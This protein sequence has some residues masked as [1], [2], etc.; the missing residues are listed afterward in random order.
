MQRRTFLQGSIA[1]AVAAAT[2]PQALAQ[3]AAA[4][5]ANAPPAFPPVDDRSVWLVGDWG[6]PP[7]AVV[8]STRLATLV[9][10]RDDVK[11]SYLDGGAVA[12]L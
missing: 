10:G 2:S 8:M 11:D 3:Y 12:E 5:A 1:A 9:Q 4:P 6:A 7:D